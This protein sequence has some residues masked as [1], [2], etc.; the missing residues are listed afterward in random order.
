MKNN[1]IIFGYDFNELDMILPFID[2]VLTTNKDNVTLY[3][4]LK[5]IS[6]AD[7]HLEY[8]RTR[9]HLEQKYFLEEQCFSKYKIVINVLGKIEQL[10]HKRKDPI[11]RK[12]RIPCIGYLFS[13]IILIIKRVSEYEKE[14]LLITNKY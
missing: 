7:Y 9:H 14:H 5:N 1:F 6:G 3:T 8:L 2:S 10:Q 4:G 13:L 12:T 11:I